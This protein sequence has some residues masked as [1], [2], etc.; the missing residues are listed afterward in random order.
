MIFMDVFQDNG[1][2]GYTI[3]QSLYDIV[4]R[5]NIVQDRKKCWGNP[6]S[7]KNFSEQTCYLWLFHPLYLG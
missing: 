6:G 7:G 1:G 4:E 3:L 2:H 5:C